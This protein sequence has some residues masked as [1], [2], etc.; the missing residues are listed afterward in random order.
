ML[1]VVTLS[2]CASSPAVP[3]HPTPNETVRIVGPA[4]AVALT[5]SPTVA[6]SV[7]TIHAPLDQVWRVLPAVYDSLAIPLTTLDAA[8][9]VIGNAGIKLRGRLGNIP[10][11]RYLDCGDTQ[12]TPS[13]ETYEIHLSVFTQVQPGTSGTTTVA[14]TVQA[15]GRPVAFSGEYVRCPS[16]GALEL[17]LV[18]TL[19]AHLPR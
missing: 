4:G 11:T 8:N 15:R 14:T 5:M 2:G 6:A 10:L 9:H 16:N 12:G 13:A 19:N 7:T 1:S 18:N 3:G 17:R